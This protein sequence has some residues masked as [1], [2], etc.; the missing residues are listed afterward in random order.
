MR[1]GQSR[2][3]PP[4]NASPTRTLTP[5]TRYPDPIPKII[6]FRSLTIFAGASGVGKTIMLSE[7]LVRIRDGRT[8]WGHPTHQPTGFYYLAGD[9]PWEPTF[10]ETFAVV[11]FDVP[12]YSLADDRKKRR[13]KEWLTLKADTTLLEGILRD[14]LQPIPGSLVVL[15]P[16]YPLFT[17]GNQNDAKA[18]AATL[19]WFRDLIWEFQITLICCANV[20][21][22]R[23]GDK[24][25]RSQDRVS[26]SGAFIAYSDTNMYMHDGDGEGGT[27]FG[28]T[29]RRHP[30]EEFRVE[31][32]Y[33]TQLFVPYSGV[34]ED[35]PEADI[36]A[37]MEPKIPLVYALI[38][39][40][41]ADKAA[42]I[43]TAVLT[44]LAAE[45]AS[46]ATIRRYLDALVKR[47]LIERDWGVV[48]RVI[49]VQRQASQTP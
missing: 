48:R 1:P 45:I 31:F 21:K 8:V 4:S 17:L 5:P 37:T 19:H 16:A 15:D 32:D 40:V 18:V 36:F 10:E 35:S 46:P 25:R 20:A 44:T 12:H 42:W 34:L 11:G 41:V 30:A 7:M 39:A 38:P 43:E 47:G 28:W 6:P 24:I 14:K 27:V 9:R 13:P 26:G 3:T 33:K 29:P 23:E 2:P 49:R 22:E